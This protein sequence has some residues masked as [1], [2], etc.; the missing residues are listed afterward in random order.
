MQDGRLEQC[1]AELEKAFARIDDL[2][3]V[4]MLEI[5]TSVKRAVLKLQKDEID[6]RILNTLN[7]LKVHTSATDPSSQI[8][9][10]LGSVQSS[11]GS[12]N[13]GAIMPGFG[14]KDFV[15][16]MNSKARI[17]DVVDLKANKT[18]KTDSEN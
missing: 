18:N 1:E 5:N 10:N 13:V 16:M 2:K 15:T 8:P 6:T 4:L 11:G 7:K 14:F 17:E 3:Y 9:T 12:M